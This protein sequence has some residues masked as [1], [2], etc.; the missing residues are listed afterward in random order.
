M[1]QLTTVQQNFLGYC[2]KGQLSSAMDQAKQLGDLTFFEKVQGKNA[3]IL[4]AENGKREIIEWLLEQ[5]LDI[6]SKDFDG[7]TALHY[8]AS[9]GDKQMCLFLMMN[10]ADIDQPD[11]DK[12][13]PADNDY[14]MKKFLVEVDERLI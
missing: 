14:D 13:C 6:K 1:A 8:A 5:N 7:K 2:E 11:N 9:K 10:R 12:K 4:A 3:L